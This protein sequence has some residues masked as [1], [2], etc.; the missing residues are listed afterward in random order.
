[1]LLILLGV[2][3]HRDSKNAHKGESKSQR[4]G[5][6]G[7]GSA[8]VAAQTRCTPKCHLVSRAVRSC[9]ETYTRPTEDAPNRCKPVVWL[10]SLLSA[11]GSLSLS[12][13]P[14]IPRVFPANGKAGA[15]LEVPIGVGDG[16]PELPFTMLLSS[17]CLPPGDCESQRLWIARLV[18]RDD[19][20][21]PQFL[22]EVLSAMGLRFAASGKA[23]ELVRWG[24]FPSVP[25][26][27]RRQLEHRHWVET[28]QFESA[29]QV[30]TPASLGAAR[31]LL[32]ALWLF[33]CLSA[34]MSGFQCLRASTTAKNK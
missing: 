7:V 24:P 5:G 33:G 14:R 6:Q 26:P 32:L 2:H 9:Q 30:S 11:N 10:S 16:V 28:W 29:R 22:I 4:P 21:S 19:A 1:M 13:K 15:P 8:L 31:A 17:G 27:T 34:G 23:L 20:M 3:L 18:A 12:R 25:L